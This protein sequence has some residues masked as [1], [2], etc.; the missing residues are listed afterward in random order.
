MT[1]RKCTGEEKRQYLFMLYLSAMS[2][3]K[4]PTH[5]RKESDQRLSRHRKLYIQ[6]HRKLSGGENILH[7]HVPAYQIRWEISNV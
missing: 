7:S 3:A 5:P 2:C 1:E 4:H 6:M